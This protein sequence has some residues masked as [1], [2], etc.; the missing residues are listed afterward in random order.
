MSFDP[1]KPVQ[2]RD[3][4]AARI[5]CT[6]RKDSRFPIIALVTYANGSE[7]PSYYTKNGGYNDPICNKHSPGDLINIPEKHV[8]YMNVFLIN[9]TISN[10]SLHHTKEVAEKSCGSGE[11]R[12]GCIKIE[13]TEGEGLI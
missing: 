2:T 10:G 1:S 4:R 3:G 11:N 13:F 6:D 5:L 7:T 9:G 8:R 12:V